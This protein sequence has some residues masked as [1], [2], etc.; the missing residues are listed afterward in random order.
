MSNISVVGIDLAKNVFQIHGN[1]KQGKCVLRKRVSRQKL[2]E[3]MA[4][5]PPCLVG[6]E[7]CGG[8]HYWGRTLQE[9]GHTVKIMAPQ[10]VKPYVKSNKTDR[11]DAEGIAEAVTR[12]NMRFV[13]IK[14]VEQQDALLIHRAR[15]LVMRQRTAQA[16]QIRGLL[17]EY[18]IIVAK[19]IQNLEEIMI[20]I[21]ENKERLSIKA[22]G[23][24]KRLCEQFKVFEAEMEY[25]NKS[26]EQTVKQD[27]M[28]Q[29]ILKIEGVGPITASAITAT[30]GDAKAFKNGREV[31]AW[32]GLVP[33]QNSSGDKVRLG[34]ITKR[35][36]RYVRKLLVH[37]ARAVV[38]VTGNK[39]DRRSMWINDKRKRLGF[40]K[41]AVALANK[42]ARIIWAMLATGEDYRKSGLS[43]TVS[44]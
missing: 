37:G 26:I 19:G 24:L 31:S 28:C 34:G 16:N 15:E 6:I 39:T 32:L 17:A 36:D 8:A 29:A 10:F 27:P 33:R 5:L 9:M 21:D 7:A 25:Y 20:I 1:D 14:T 42:N 3:F 35:G 41:A 12:P 4:Q 11:N 30:I 22:Q 23:I 18:G 43:A 40:N 38:R 2:I 13:P 44:I